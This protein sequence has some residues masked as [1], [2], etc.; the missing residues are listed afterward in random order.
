MLQLTDCSDAVHALASGSACGKAILLG[1]HAVVYGQPAIA[2][3]IVD[4]RAQARVWAGSPGT[5]PAVYAA[6]LAARFTPESDDQRGTG[7][8][9]A[10]QAAIDAFMGQGPPLIDLEIELRSLVPMA[11]GMGSSAATS[12]AIVRAIAAH[13]HLSLDPAVLSRLV[14][15][16]EM[17]YHGNPSGV[18]NT[19]VAFERPVWFTRGSAPVF[20]P[21][22][23]SLHLL[24]ADTGVPS[25]TRDTV[26]QV[27]AWRERDAATVDGLTAAIGALVCQ[28]REHLDQG[29]LAGLGQA[30]S[31]NHA[32][33]RLL[34]VSTPALDTLVEAASAA[35]ALGAKLCGGG[36]GGCAVVLCPS[37]RA[38]AISAA[39]RRAGAQKLYE[40]T[41]AT[42]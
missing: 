6:D 1:E 11:R 15:L 18:D 36:G 3:P 42:A 21:V 17:H 2:V 16:A 28:A 7:L 24:L 30:M 32:L 31:A 9:L 41:I 34:G 37:G 22:G 23:V 27:R 20:M 35:G 38:D 33:L 14:Y 25:R 5:G 29:D 19:V 12:A 13:A 8:V 40:T 39:L 4:V 26:A 10:A